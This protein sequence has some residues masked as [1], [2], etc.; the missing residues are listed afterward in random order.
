M[1]DTIY[2]IRHGEKPD[3]AAAPPPYGVRRGGEHCAHSLTPRGWQRG[4]ALAV[5]FTRAPYQ[6]PEHLLCP[7]YD[8]PRTKWHRPYQTLTALHDLTKVPITFDHKVEDTAAVASAV[9]K[10]PGVVLVCWEH[11]NI[12]PIARGVAPGAGVPAQFPDR[13][14]LIWRLTRTGDGGYAFAELTQNT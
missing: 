11:K 7:R 8:E 3:P 1:P 12:P 4:G 9:L 13:F 6:Q 5:L 14:D 2:L 10:L